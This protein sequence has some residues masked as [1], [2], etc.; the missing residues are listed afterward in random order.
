MSWAYDALGRVTGKGQTIGTVTQ[1][2]GYSYTNGDLISLITP[3]GQTVVYSYVNHRINSIMVNGTAILSGVTY[4]PFG[5]A[6]A[7]SWGNGTTVSRTFDQDGNPSQFISAGTTNGYTVDNASRI[8]GLSDSG[9]TSNSFTFG[10]DLLDRVTSGTSSAITRGYSYDANGN[11]LATTGTVAFTDSIATTSNQLNSTTG[12]IART[13]GY[14]A[15]GNTLGYGGNSFT[16]NQRG[17]MSSANFGGATYYVYNALGQL[18]EKYSTGRATLLVYDEAWAA[19]GS[20][21][22]TLG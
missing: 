8:T 7:W 16:F 6:N 17:R 5:P 9:L 14:D 15:A 20:V 22:T 18:I 10:Y 3:S 13:Y 2:V 1:S 21:D 19:A 12:G 11:Q 4:D